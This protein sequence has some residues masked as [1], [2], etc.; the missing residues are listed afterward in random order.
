MFGKCYLQIRIKER[1]IMEYKFKTEPY[2]HQ[3]KALGASHNRENY[4]LFMEMG[5][6]KSKVLV[7]N[8]AMLYDKG[9]INAA[10]IVAPKGVYRNWE[11]QEIP[12]HMPDH[13]VHNVVTWSPVTTKKQQKE[14]LKL[15][16]HGEQLTIFLMNIEAFS[17]KKGLDIAQRFLLAH[18]TLMAI[19]ESTTIKSPTA[20]R[21]KNV[22]KLRNY[23]K[24]RRILTGSPVTKSPLDLYTQC[25]FLDPYYLDF[26]SYYTF[27]NRYASMVDRNVGSHSFKLV[28]G[29]VRLDEL[30]DKLNKFSYRVLKEDCLDL[31]EKV[32]MKRIVSLTPEQLKAY[33]E[34][35]KHALAELDGKMTSAASA[36]AQMVR[37]HQ[38]TCGHLATDDGEVTQ[39]KNNRINELLDVIEEVNGKVIIWAIYRHDIKQIENTLAEKYGQDSVKSFYGDT[40]DSDRQD[41]VNAFQDRESNLRFFVGNPRTG[42]YGLTLTASHTVV[43]Y[44]NSYDLEIRLQ[45]EDRAHRI[46]QKEKVTYVDLIS[47]KT[48]D[49]FIV[50]NL[51]AKINLA[52]KVLGEDLKKWLI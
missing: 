24:Y 11:R 38:I 26:T 32:Y 33:T 2:A 14:N 40:A 31:P 47:E 50:K 35:K 23:A 22:L 8:I 1:D 39:V 21:T 29:Y 30:N 4:A 51:R 28:T 43:Y 34:M 46:G 48:I 36:L 20:R 9:K 18:Q 13:I 6:G 49:E 52:T 5:T 44:S 16:K 41:I 17:T 12:I 7:D 3:L 37:L 10:L 25:Y 15:F 27:R 42:G 19:D 45:S